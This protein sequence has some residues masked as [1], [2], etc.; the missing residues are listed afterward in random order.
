[1]ALWSDWDEVLHH[2]RRYDRRG[3]RALFDGPAW[4]LV[5]VNYTNVLAYPAVWALRRWRSLRP[6]RPGATRAEDRVPPAALNAMLRASFHRMAM[7]RLP[8]PFGVS[9]LLVARRR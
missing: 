6:A 5:H 2:Q 1:M 9:L 4:E 7:S 8:F 3:L